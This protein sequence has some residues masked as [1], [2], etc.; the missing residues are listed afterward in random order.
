MRL[1]LVFV[2]RGLVATAIACAALLTV[3]TAMGAVLVATGAISVADDYS[4]AEIAGAWFLTAAGLLSIAR[5]GYLAA[6]ALGA[7]SRRT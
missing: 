6:Q 3:I 5:L 7:S 1:A 4:L 2:L